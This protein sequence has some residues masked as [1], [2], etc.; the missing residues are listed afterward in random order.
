M[1]TLIIDEDHL[2]IS[3]SNTI[4]AYNPVP[5]GISA[6]QHRL[7]FATF[8]GL[9]LPFTVNSSMPFIQQVME[10][11]L[12]NTNTVQQQHLTII[13]S[14][15]VLPMVPA[16]SKEMLNLFAHPIKVVKC[17]SQSRSAI[18]HEHQTQYLHEFH[19][20]I[21]LLL[22]GNSQILLCLNPSV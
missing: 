14:L 18:F 17:L 12:H 5:A 4:V 20:L 6:Q 15:C 7:S 22:T 16:W 3:G 19:M 9:Q 1:P 2:H 21:V 11:T 10:Q 13:P 8:K